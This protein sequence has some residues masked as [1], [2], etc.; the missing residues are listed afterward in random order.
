MGLFFSSNGSFNFT[1]QVDYLIV[2]K[3]LILM[4]I[5]KIGSDFAFKLNNDWLV[6]KIYFRARDDFSKR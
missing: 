3:M 4:L 1:T 2:L 5:A 6:V